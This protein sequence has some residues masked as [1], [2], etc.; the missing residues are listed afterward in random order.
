MPEGLEPGWAK[1]ARIDL[2]AHRTPPE[3]HIRP[4]WSAAE[5][6]WTDKTWWPCTI[7]AWYRLAEPA[8]ELMTM[9]TVDWLAR[10]RT[11]DGADHWFGYW[12]SCLRPAQV[13][14]TPGR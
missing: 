14:R 2:G 1:E 11:I 10:I 12:P 8:E 6:R 4:R 7:V 9:R 5:V 13:G 3:P